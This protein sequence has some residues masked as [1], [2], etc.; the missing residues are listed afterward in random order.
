MQ[1]GETSSRSENRRLTREVGKSR[2]RLGSILRSRFA[3]V[4]FRSQTSGENTL[5]VARHQGRPRRWTPPRCRARGSASPKQ[6]FPRYETRR[7][8]SGA[9]LPAGLPPS[10]RWTCRRHAARSISRRPRHTTTA[11]AARLP[12]PYRYPWNN[13]TSTGCST[14]SSLSNS[15]GIVCSRKVAVAK[16]VPSVSRIWQSLST[17]TIPSQACI[18]G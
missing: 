18:S 3:S 14:Y 4:H 9:S 2:C 10:W 15:Q 11:N 8:G 7:R 6:R 17:D 1:A 12:P 16:T 5:R 13:V